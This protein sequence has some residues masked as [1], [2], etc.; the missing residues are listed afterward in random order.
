MTLPLPSHVTDSWQSWGRIVKAQ[1]EIV[2]P[3]FQDDVRRALGGSS[4]PSLAVGLGRS[5]GTSCLNP[6]GRLIDMRG[7]S[8]LISFDEQSGIL[9]AEAGISL[10]EIIAFALPRGFFLPTTPGTRFVTLGG[11]IANDVHGKNH[12][13]AGTFGTHIS[14]IGLYR[15]DK[16]LLDLTPETDANLF[17]ATIG[18]LGLTG[19]IV[20]A[21]LQLVKVPSG[22]LTQT[23]SRFGNLNG[24]FEQNA[25]AV[26]ESEH[27]VA[28]IDCLAKGDE[29]GR[30]VLTSA[31]WCSTGKTE[32]KG[33][34]HGPNVPFSPPSWVMNTLSIRLFNA[35]YYAYHSMKTGRSVI[36]YGS[37]FYP[38]DSIRNWNRLYGKKGMFQYQ[39]VIPEAN[40]AEATRDMLKE[41]SRAGMGSFL[42]VLKTFG[43]KPSPGMLS[44]PM[45]GTTLALDFPNKGRA[46]LKLLTE[47][48]TIVRQAGGRLYPAKDGR[49]PSDMMESGYPLLNQFL[50]QIDPALSSLFYRSLDIA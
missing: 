49:I 1:H 24:F 21:D 30:G 17:N 50:R 20:W 13:S 18:G 37:Y 48:D 32:V 14:R 6:E 40:A 29:L 35:F 15:S 8:R 46:T 36:D 27:T 9:R 45:E 7:L 47:L 16:G 22:E 26:D 28:W 19:I 42:A 4:Q 5:Y 23:I 10:W 12:H 41:I 44:F 33:P 38:L 2:S 11:A 39:S 31:D 3:G 34:G 43:D 25:K